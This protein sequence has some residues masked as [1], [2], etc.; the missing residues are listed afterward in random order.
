MVVVVVVVDVVVVVVVEVVEVVVVTVVMIVV[1]A[2]E[3]VVGVVTKLSTSGVCVVVNRKFKS[4][5]DEDLSLRSCRCVSN[6]WSKYTELGLATRDEMEELVVDGKLGIVE[7]VD[8][9]VES[10]DGSVVG[11]VAKSYL[12]FILMLIAFSCWF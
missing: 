5:G 4:R 12:T 9:M 10:V 2:V 1:V 6:N 7:V 11:G 3:G 8:V